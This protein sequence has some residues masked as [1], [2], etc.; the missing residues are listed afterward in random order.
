MDAKQYTWTVI[1]GDDEERIFQ[2][3]DAAGTAINLTGYIATLEVDIGTE[4]YSVPCAVNG[5][6][7]TVTAT[8]SNAVTATFKGA[9]KFRLKLVAPSAKVKTLAY[10]TVRVVTP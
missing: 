10:G 5:P 3:K 9:G 8:L 1:V 2:Y 7:G 6:T 4:L